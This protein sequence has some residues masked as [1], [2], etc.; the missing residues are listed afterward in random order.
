MINETYSLYKEINK[1]IANEYSRFKFG[2]THIMNKLAKQIS[3]LISS[4]ISKQKDYV[5]YTANKFPTKEYYKKNSLIL[6]E[7]I[8]KICKM[9]LVIGEYSY[10]YDK[11]NFY[12][13]SLERKIHLPKVKKEDKLKYK[14]F[15]FIMID[16]SIFT[17]TTL[18]VT[19]KELEGVVSKVLF[20]SIVNLRESKYSEEEINDVHY[21]KEGTKYITKLLNSKNY[22]LTTH[23][24]RAIDRLDKTDLKV[25]LKNIKEENMQTLQKSLKDYVGRELIIQQPSPQISSPSKQNQ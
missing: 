17:G 5:L 19:L 25:L 24:L 11:N 16:D 4:K 21:K 14:D 7:K 3:S 9:P 6:S 18:E 8:S 15:I 23:M 22:I 12:E 2:E 13:N 1:K 10:T 20:F